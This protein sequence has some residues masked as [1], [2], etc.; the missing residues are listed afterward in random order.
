[1]SKLMF[2]CSTG[3]VLLKLFQ[4]YAVEA[5]VH[6]ASKKEKCTGVIKQATPILK[7]LYQSE[8]DSIKVR[9]LVVSYDVIVLT[10][11]RFMFDIRYNAV[12]EF[13]W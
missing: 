9:A 3:F 12:I 10:L 6:S 7:R 1:M 11:V 4:K 13:P 2:D 8:N 5:L